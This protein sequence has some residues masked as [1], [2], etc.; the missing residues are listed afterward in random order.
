M[1]QPYDVETFIQ[2]WSGREGGQERANYALFLT[3]LCAALDLPAPD[4]ADANRSAND[5]VFERGVVET[6]RDG[7]KSNRR[8]DLYKRDAFVLEAKQSRQS[9]AKALPDQPGLLLEEPAA[10]GRRGADRRWDELMMNARQQ[11]EA[12]V[13]WLPDGHAPPPFILVCDVGH[14]F[15]VYANFR[16]DG[17]A[18]DQFPDRRTF[19]IYLEDLR[20]PDIQERLRAIWRDPESLDPGRRSAKVTRDIAQRLA[21]VSKTLEAEKHSSP[22]QDGSPGAS[23]DQDQLV[24]AGQP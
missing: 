13:R 15:E 16:R 14:C 9:G 3:E 22:T 21:A 6:L 11:A 19:R 24:V 4:P 17:K 12:Y 18:Y 10:R 23:L 20:R 1:A 5:Y 7:A 2:R 8:I